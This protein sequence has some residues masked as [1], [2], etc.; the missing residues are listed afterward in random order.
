LGPLVSTR[1]TNCST[2]KA[3]RKREPSQNRRD[4]TFLLNQ[5]KAINPALN[6]APVDSHVDL[7]VITSDFNLGRATKAPAH[8][9]EK[10]GLEALNLDLTD[11]VDRAAR[12]FAS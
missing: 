5:S 2:E 9:V 1:H 3:R 4:S 6:H 8:S 11:L 7:P 10:R 12:R